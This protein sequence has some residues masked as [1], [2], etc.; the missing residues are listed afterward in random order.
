MRFFICVVVEVAK[1]SNRRYMLGYFWG[2]VNENHRWKKKQV[3]SL[4]KERFEMQKTSLK[5]Y[6]K[7]WMENMFILFGLEIT[8]IV[9]LL[10]S[11]ALLNAISLLYI[12][13]LA[14]CVVLNRQLVKRSWLLFV[15][16]FATVLLLEYF[17]IWKTEENLRGLTPSDATLHCHDCWRI[18]ELHFNFCRSCWLGTALLIPCFIHVILNNAYLYRKK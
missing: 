10:A 11:F 4:R 1:T 6:L 17:A 5:I 12:A 3:Q 2:Q 7:F 9:L 18:S 14:V 8:M 15:V 13:S 16:L